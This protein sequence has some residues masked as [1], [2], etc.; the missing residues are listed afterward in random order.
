MRKYDSSYYVLPKH[1]FDGQV[2]SNKARGMVSNGSSIW[3]ICPSCNKGHW[4]RCTDLRISIHPKY[5]AKCVPSLQDHKEK[6]RVIMLKRFEDKNERDK[7][8]KRGKEYYANHPEYRR[9]QAKNLI[10]YKKDPIIREK[11]I[12]S[13]KETWN[14]QEM[15]KNRGN[16][17]KAMWEQPGFKGNMAI[18]RSKLLKDTWANF[19]PEH[20]DKRI[21]AMFAGIRRKLNKP[22]RYLANLLNFSYPNDWKYVGDGQITIEGKNPDFINI[23]G[24]KEV[25]ELYGNYWHGKARTGF[26][27]KEEVQRKEKIYAKYGYKTLVIW[28]HELDNPQKVLSRIDR[29]V[30]QPV[31]H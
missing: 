30:N 14:N 28:E 8:S 16:M 18:T 6:L 13:I 25:I 11:W 22:E 4:V 12:K 7:V 24:K 23:N 1:L 17:F 29:F 10:G 27:S 21:K 20:K 15:K 5:C 9:S 19:T 2:I 3:C 26:E 31:L